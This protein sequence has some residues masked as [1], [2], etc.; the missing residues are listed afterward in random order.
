MRFWMI[1]FLEHQVWVTAYRLCSAV[2]R[3][4]VKAFVAGNLLVVVALMFSGFAIPIRAPC[5]RLLLLLQ[6][7][8]LHYVF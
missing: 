6:N 1:L 5:S 8:N 7:A 4:L 3:V 2:G